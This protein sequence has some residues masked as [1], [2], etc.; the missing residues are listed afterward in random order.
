MTVSLATVL[1]GVSVGLQYGLLAMGLVLIYRSSRVINFAQGQLGVTS[2]VLLVH[3][4]AD[5][6]IPY[7]VALPLVLVVA[8]A[9]GAGCELT[10][11]RLN[12]RPRL[13]VM[14]ATI[15]LAQ[16]LVLFSLLPFVRPAH[17]FVAFPLPFHLSFT[18]NDFI[19]QPGD[20]VTFIVA[21][22][23]AIGLAVYFARS[24][25]GLRLRAAVE[26]P[27]SARISGV[28]VRR[29]STLAWVIAGLL[30]AVAAILA[31]PGQ[32][33]SFSQALG[34]ELLLR[35]LTAALIAGMTNLTVA[36]VAGI[37]IGIIQQILT[38]NWIA[39]PN[40]VDL[41]MFGL[42]LLALIVRISR[43]RRT[44][45]NDERADWRLAIA[46]SLRAQE[47]LRRLIGRSGIAVMVAL[48]L[49]L[50]VLMS[51][52]NAYLMSTVLVFA[53]IAISLTI[54][55]G[56]AGQLSLGQMAFVAVGTVVYARLADS[57]SLPLVMLIAGA[58]G[59][60]VA[61]A[62]GIPALR[63]PGPYLAVTTL[64]LALVVYKDVLATPC[65]HLGALGHVCSGL[66]EPSDTFVQR[67]HIFGVDLTSERTTAYV[68][69]AVLLIVLIAAV[70]WRDRGLARLLLAVRGNEL[71]AA[72]MGVR[73]VRAKLIAFAVSGFIAGVAG[74]CFG[75]VQQRVNAD[76]FL[77]AQSILIVAMV[78]VGGLGSL[79]GAVLGALY[80]IGSRAIFGASDTAEFLTSGI[81]LLVFLLFLPAG[82]SGLASGAADRVTDLIKRVGGRRYVA[83]APDPDLA[84]PVGA[85]R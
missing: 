29:M 33:S 8:A 58:I 84:E 34:P 38:T 25:T 57:L 41:V 80:L 73:T 46:T 75:L 71:A 20:V 27:E 68:V 64:G 17:L 53:L 76:Q 12:A 30:S 55:A 54:L 37:G 78:V 7:G 40:R 9:I 66:P 35:A 85:S 77:P 44:A 49:V 19:F 70:A 24:K 82:L 39:A 22:V 36:F 28:Y 69:L 11:R 14:V 63:I 43:L 31:S 61:V 56:W 6:H 16:V 13:L 67:P 23:V 79:S 5:E 45:A 74:V 21:P 18:L 60:V 65:V 51:Q 26:N 59:A 4:T 32:G 3:L 50:P 1:N 10:L 62:I 2:A 52:H 81:G 48:A 83:T 72:A 42:I 15:G 47:S